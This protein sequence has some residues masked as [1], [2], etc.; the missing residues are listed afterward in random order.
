[1]KKLMIATVMAAALPAFADT[2]EDYF[3]AMEASL[4]KDGAYSEEAMKIVRDQLA[5]VPADQHEAFCKAGIEG[6]K[7]SENDSEQEADDAE[8][9]GEEKEETS[10]G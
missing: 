10:K 4:K 5:A 2:C 9:E 8:E 1:M 3:A 6:L 7:A